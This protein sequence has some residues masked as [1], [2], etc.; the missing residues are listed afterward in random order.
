MFFDDK[1]NPC[2]KHVFLSTAHENLDEF[3][4][5]V[6]SFWYKSCFKKCLLQLCS[7]QNYAAPVIHPRYLVSDSCKIQ[8]RCILRIPGRHHN[9]LVKWC[10]TWKKSV[11][12]GN[13]NSPNDRSLH[14]L[15]TKP[16]FAHFVSF[17]LGG[18]VPIDLFWQNWGLLKV[19]IK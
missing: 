10:E 17:P 15:S 9:F 11:F 6:M 1:L 14:L 8:H 16:N 7:I 13:Y 18:N 12:V 5:S 4:M 2:H 19:F 3:V